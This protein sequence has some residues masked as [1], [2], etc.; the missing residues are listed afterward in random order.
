M[1]TDTFACLHILLYQ[2][3]DPLP[4]AVHTGIDPGILRPGAAYPPA[5][6]ANQI[7]PVIVLLQP[8]NIYHYIL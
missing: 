7:P 6:D 8:E 4:E 3:H 5:H 1:V 2:V